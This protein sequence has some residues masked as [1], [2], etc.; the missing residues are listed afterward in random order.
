M[1]RIIQEGTKIHYATDESVAKAVVKNLNDRFPDPV[2]LSELEKDNHEYMWDLGGSILQS[3]KPSLVTS[4]DFKL[5]FW[6]HQLS[7]INFY[8][9]KALEDVRV[10]DDTRYIKLHGQWH[11]LC[12]SED[13]AR[14]LHSKIKSS[15][16]ELQKE[17]TAALELWESVLDDMRKNPHPNVLIPEKKKQEAN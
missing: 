11:C 4:N 7:E 17:A 5:Y 10:E 13:M 1:F 8:F 12:L 14:S 2:E 16:A 3:W 6:P 15:Q 9:N